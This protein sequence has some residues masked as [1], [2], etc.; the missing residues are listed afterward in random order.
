MTCTKLFQRFILNHCRLT[1]LRAHSLWLVIRCGR[2][3]QGFKNERSDRLY[4][5][6][7]ARVERIGTPSVSFN[8][9][10]L[11]LI[12][13]FLVMVRFEYLT[14]NMQCTKTSTFQE[15]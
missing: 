10:M 7:Y 9:D 15:S 4:P 5:D 12:P 11:I 3:C 2:H 14:P 6:R 13:T 8:Q 1:H